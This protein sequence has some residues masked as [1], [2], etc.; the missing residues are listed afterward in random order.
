[1]IQASLT[2]RAAFPVPQPAYTSDTPIN[3]P[4]AMGFDMCLW[5]VRS[6]NL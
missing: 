6:F 2:Q 5:N 4:I 1:M 3:A